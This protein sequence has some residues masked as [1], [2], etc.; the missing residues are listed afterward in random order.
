[1]I[2]VP[3]DFA[4]FQPGDPIRFLTNDNGFGGLGLY[5]RTGTVQHATDRALTVDCDSNALGKRALIRRAAWS[6]RAPERA[7]NSRKGGA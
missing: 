1:M 3:A 5:W 6:D 7:T 2:F 4:D